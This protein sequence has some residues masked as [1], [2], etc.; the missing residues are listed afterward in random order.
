MKKPTVKVTPSSRA[1]NVSTSGILRVNHS[2][3][4]AKSVA[5]S[6]TRKSFSLAGDSKLLDKSSH[7]TAK[8]VVQVFDDSGKAVTPQPLYHPDPGAVSKQSKIFIGHDASGATAS[9][10]FSATYQTTNASSAGPFTK[11][12]FGSSTMS[13]SSQSTMGSMSDETEDPSS[14]RYISNSLSD[15]QVRREEVKEQIREDMLDEVVDRYLSET[16]TIWLLDLPGVSVSVESEEAAVVKEKNKEYTELCKN[17]MGNDKY[18]ERMMQTFNGAPKTKQVQSETITMVDTGVTVTTWDM[19][20]TFSTIGVGETTKSAEKEKPSCLEAVSEHRHDAARSSEKTT[21][22]I[23]SISTGSSSSSHIE[24]EDFIETKDEVDPQL[25]LQSEKFQHSLFV[26]ERILLENILQP[27]LAA[28]RQLP[29]LEDPYC[30]KDSEDAGKGV[31]KEE[32]T[33]TPALERLWSYS[34]VQTAGLSVTS[35][36]W[37]KR[38]PDLL[39]VGYGTFDFKED[40]P[41][42]VCCWSLK[43]PMWPERVIQC[44]S[45]VTALDFS[46][47]N[48]SQL[49]V[50][51][52][53]GIVATYSVQSNEKTHVVDSSDC[54][55]KHKAAVWQVKWINMERAV[56]GE[57]KGEALISVSAD[58]RLCKWFMRKGLECI[59]MMKLKR[60]DKSKK[61]EEKEGKGE[62]LISRQAPGLC[63]DFHAEDTIIYLVG[64]EEGYIHK[65]SCSYN[66]QYLE[67]YR[68]HEGPLYRI[69]WSPFCPDIFLSCAADWT[70]QLW[71]Q[72]LM[73]PILSFT[74]GQRAVFDVMW[75]PKWATVFGTVN[76]DRVEIWNLGSCI[77]DPTI[78]S[79]AGPGVKFTSLLFATDTDCILVGDSEGQVSVYQLKNLDVGAGPQVD[80]LEEIIRSTLSSRH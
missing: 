77:L 33:L 63:F 51:M 32:G 74:S 67:T 10:F 19:Y 50:G 37:N 60:T 35:M 26:M 71:R 9:D 8:R 3:T 79:L 58:G 38:N 49:A 21:S 47:N 17:R 68:G 40:K 36:A 5:A 22:V 53:A 48:S 46:A 24:A 13:R 62:V 64:T 39:A 41:G 65:C 23:S 15:I 4:N 7:Q 31:E 28:Y 42:R 30:A 56:M 12:V 27:K 1:T 6:V 55:H 70:V 20:D 43:N 11:S 44:G 2:S 76:E 14:K 52:K 66:E 16:D 29:I 59:D 57:D 25:I 72:D 45:S 73:K 80:T 61:A 69:T 18:V 78:V 54:S 34:C 75:S